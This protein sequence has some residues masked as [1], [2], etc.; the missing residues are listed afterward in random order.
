MPS[1][2][3]HTIKVAQHQ[4]MRITLGIIGNT[5]FSAEMLDEADEIGPALAEV[6]RY[7][8]TEIDRIVHLPMWWPTPRISRPRRALRRL[9]QTIYRLIC[10]RRASGQDAGDILSMLLAAQE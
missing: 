4:M 7:V 5:L 2:G 9:D 10:E 1:G 3:V 8:G 6:N